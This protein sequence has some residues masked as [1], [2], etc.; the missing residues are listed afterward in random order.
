MKKSFLVT[1]AFVAAL[2]LWACG[3]DSSASA[4]PA[5]DDSSSVSS[6]SNDAQDDIDKKSDTSKDANNKDDS[7][8][9]SS[10]SSDDSDDPSLCDEPEC[11]KLESSS[12]TDSASSDDTEKKDDASSD[13][14]DTKAD[15]ALWT[16]YHDPD[17]ICVMTAELTE[18]SNYDFTGLKGTT[19]CTEGET[20]Y[21]GA[22][23]NAFDKPTDISS[24]GGLCVVYDSPDRLFRIGMVPSDA[25]TYTENNNYVTYLSKTNG[26]TTIDIPWEE[27]KQMLPNS[28][29][30]K[31]EFL[32]RVTGFTIQMEELNTTSDFTLYKIGKMGECSVS[33][34]SSSN[35]EPAS[36]AEVD[37]LWNFYHDP[38]DACAMTAEPT[39]F[40]DYDF[41]GLK[42]TTVCTAG[43]TY[44]AGATKNIFDKPTDISS[45]GGLCV[46]YESSATYFRIGMI[47]D[48]AENFTKNSNYVTYL[49]KA[50]GVT[51][52]DIPWEKFELVY[53][54]IVVEQEEFLK[55]I[56]GYSIQM[57][58][59]NSTS[60]FT[61]YKIGK[62]GS[63]GTPTEGD[64]FYPF[65]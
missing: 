49:G 33:V 16:F 12:S 56:I 65:S 3:D 46:A 55:R 34:E 5:N 20:Y 13:D 58:E 42:G 53:P 24:W 27:F 50:E 28:L 32:G 63:C 30:D 60:D 41:T 48:D 36:S 21:A 47:P 4:D 17:S 1:T 9:S 26:V 51:V 11:D 37:T 40:A 14:S 57:E 25:D 2:G 18:F 22:I 59:P 44:Y 8:N 38:E 54:T 61:L 15:D 39:A 52:V 23:Y 62:M 45:W 43:E 64:F 29:V 35:E 7:K 19:V 6:D 10:A 31:Q